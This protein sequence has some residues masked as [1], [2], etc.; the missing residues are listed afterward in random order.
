MDTSGLNPTRRDRIP[1]PVWNR[2][3]RAADF[4]EQHAHDAQGQ[5]LFAD[6]ASNL[7]LAKNTTGATLDRYSIV[8]FGA[9]QTD[10]ALSDAAKASFL[11]RPILTASQP[12]GGE[13]SWGVAVDP[14]AANAIGR[15]AIGG[16]VPVKIS[17]SSATHKY[18]K[19]QQYGTS[20]LVS[21][22]ATEGAATILWKESGTGTKWAL[23][24]LGSGGSPMRLC[25]TTFA[26]NKGTLATLDVWE[27]GTPP[28][29][30]RTS[31]E[32]IVD[33]VN[34]FAN[35]AA[36]KFVSVAM[37]GNG[38]WYVVAAEC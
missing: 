18:A 31:S 33:V 20:Q 29:E 19:T 37:H 24:R 17:V 21:G 13:V 9:I 1:V 12:D 26:F 38:R 35:I 7:V 6:R 34:K 11:S 5:A 15:I 23:I 8:K 32:A 3:V 14:M 36:G 27:T 25:K 28:N 4:V 30:T 22:G 2:V 10:P 16:V